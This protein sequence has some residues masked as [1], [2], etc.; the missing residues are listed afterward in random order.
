MVIFKSRQRKFEGDLKIQFCGKRLH[1]TESVKYTGVK[2]DI[3]LS[4]QYHLNDLSIKLNRANAFLFKM[5]KYVS[6]KIL[7]LI[8]FTISDSYLS[9]CLL[10]WAQ[11][12]STI[13]QRDSNT[14]SCAYFKIFRYYFFQR[15]T[16]VA[17][18]EVSFSIRKEL[19]E[20]KLMERCHVFKR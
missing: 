9:H 15:A 14:F 13:Q 12:C 5:R 20:R 16:T 11:N 1:H 19:L 3:K 8:C 18:F 7:R 10:V 6:L 2:I 4:F 17:A